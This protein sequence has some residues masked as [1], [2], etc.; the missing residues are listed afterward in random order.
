[1]E[2]PTNDDMAPTPSRVFS[3]FL[4]FSSIANKESLLNL[5]RIYRAFSLRSFV[6]VRDKCNT[7]ESNVMSRV[8]FLVVASMV[9]TTMILAIVSTFTSNRWLLITTGALAT[10]TALTTITTAITTRDGSRSKG[11][12]LKF[13]LESTWATNIYVVTNIMNENTK[14]ITMSTKLMVP[15]VTTGMM[16]AYGMLSTTAPTIYTQQSK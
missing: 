15:W 8:A 1:M 16:N 3:A 11:F 13:Y 5:I 7:G 6:G 10:A 14:S 9:L 4:L 2:A 12:E